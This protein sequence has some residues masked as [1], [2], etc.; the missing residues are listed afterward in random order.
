MEL[1]RFRM[2]HLD[3]AM[4]LAYENYL[5]ECEVTKSRPMVENV[6]DLSYFASN[7]LGI[8]ALEDNQLVGFWA[9]CQPWDKAFGSNVKGTFTPVHAHGAVLKN[10]AYIYKRMYQEIAK[11]LVSN[12]IMYHAISFYAHDNIAKDAMWQYGFGMRCAD[13]MKTL[14]HR[15]VILTEGITY[16]ELSKERVSEARELRR[17]LFFHL[18]QSPSF[19]SATN[20]QFANWIQR[21]EQRSSRLFVARDVNEIVAFFEVCDDGETFISGGE[22]ARHLCGAYCIEQYRGKVAG[23]LLSYIEQTL[24]DEGIRRLGVDCETFNPTAYG[25]WSKHFDIYT[26][27]LT[28]R[29]DE[30]AVK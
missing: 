5:E 9:Y 6:A 20:E 2:Q 21:A 19:M 29:I 16:E 26:H 11:E 10:R 14:V 28:R 23:G 30:C 15:D 12:E 17:C 22:G 4:K 25:F 27:S 24:Y 3:A 18:H 13:A 1:V 7:G 8:V